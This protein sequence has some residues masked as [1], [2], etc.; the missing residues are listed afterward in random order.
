MYQENDRMPIL[1]NTDRKDEFFPKC[2]FYVNTI[3]IRFCVRFIFNEI[4]DHLQLQVILCIN[5]KVFRGHI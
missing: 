3:N 2:L 1:N 5:Y 4:G